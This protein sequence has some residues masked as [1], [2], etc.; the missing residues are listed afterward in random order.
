MSKLLIYSKNKKIRL[1]I[2]DIIK[3]EPTIK[4]KLSK[5]SMKILWGY[6]PEIIGE[7]ANPYSLAIIILSMNKP[8]PKNGLSTN[9]SKEISMILILPIN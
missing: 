1:N 5:I 8:R 3:K 7:K 6:Q 2:K 9:E 4:P